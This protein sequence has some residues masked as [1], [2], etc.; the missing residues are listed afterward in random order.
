[1]GWQ[2]LLRPLTA[3]LNGNDKPIR[4]L[5]WPLEFPEVFHRENPGFDAIIGN[6]PFL[7]GSKI[8]ST[9]GPTYLDWLLTLHAHSHG[10]GDIVA[11][12]FRCAYDLLRDGGCFG[13]LA[14][15]TIRQGDTRATGLRPI[16]KAGGTICRDAP[17]QVAG[18]GIAL[19]R[20]SPHSCSIAAAM[21]IP[22]L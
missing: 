11:H 5:H 17:A 13:L 3:A 14:T 15:N 4:P 20:L 7:G 18:R 10:D 21:T 1:M 19:C 16:R 12:F 8:S 6:P 2:D 9:H 22:N